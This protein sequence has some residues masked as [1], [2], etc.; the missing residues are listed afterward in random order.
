MR[1]QVVRNFC[2]TGDNPCKGVEIA[3][4]P[5]TAVLASSAGKVIYSGDGIRGYGNLLIIKHD[6]EFFSVYG[7]NEKNLVKSGAF[8]SKGQKIALSGTPPGGG[9]ARLHFEIRHGKQ[10]VDP[11]LYLP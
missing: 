1:G 10:S 8:V 11:A 5:G 2:T 7:F 3:T 6:K 9:K 4:A